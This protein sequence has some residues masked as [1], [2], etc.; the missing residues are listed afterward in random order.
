MLFILGNAVLILSCGWL[1]NMSTYYQLE[2]LINREPGAKTRSLGTCK[3]KSPSYDFGNFS[4]TKLGGAMLERI[5][6]AIDD[7]CSMIC[8]ITRAQ[9]VLL[10]ELETKC[11]ISEQH[12][13]SKVSSKSI[14]QF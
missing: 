10:Q 5:Q 14:R 8:D 4:C 6:Q 13:K 3:N 12:K 7:R 9:D 11:Q 2:C 1:G